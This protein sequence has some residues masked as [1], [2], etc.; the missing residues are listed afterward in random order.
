MEANSRFVDLRSDLSSGKISC[1][2]LVSQYLTNIRA[3]EDLNAWVGVYADEALQHAKVIDNKIRQGT[4]G[5]LAGMV[6]GIKD[7]LS[8]AGHPL[9]AGSNILN[10]F[11]ASFT[12]TAVQRLID[13][14]AIIIGRQNCN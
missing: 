3:Q 1:Y 7:V 11:H 4:A 8:H 10:G 2:D 6:V 5:R 14:D 9:Q 12:A 13:A